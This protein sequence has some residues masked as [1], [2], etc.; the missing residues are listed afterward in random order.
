MLEGVAIG[1]PSQKSC[2]WRN[3]PRGCCHVGNC[4]DKDL[5]STSLF[6]CLAQGQHHRMLDLF[7][8]R[9]SVIPFFA[10]VALRTRLAG[11]KN[12]EISVKYQKT[13]LARQTVWL[14]VTRGLMGV[15]GEG[16]SRRFWGSLHLSI[17]PTPRDTLNPIPWGNCRILFPPSPPSLFDVNHA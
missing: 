5:E 3:F 13:W 6:S 17:V 16:S 14:H 12:D 9:I 1:L 10:P 4:I 15:E 8:T 7:D 2:Y 11:R